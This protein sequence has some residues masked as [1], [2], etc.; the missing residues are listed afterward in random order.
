[1]LL[2]IHGFN[3][4]PLSHKANVMKQYCEQSRPDIKV[5]VPKLPCFSSPGLRVVA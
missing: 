2:Y 4:S 5:V 3:S 1:M